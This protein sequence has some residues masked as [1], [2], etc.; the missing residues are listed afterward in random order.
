MV[1]VTGF[2]AID[3]LVGVPI[4]LL[5]GLNEIRRLKTKIIWAGQQFDGVAY[6]HRVTEARTVFRNVHG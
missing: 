4:K 1:V 2:I 3:L 6:P 5:L